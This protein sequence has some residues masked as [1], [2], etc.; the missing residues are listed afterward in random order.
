LLLASIAAGAQRFSFG[1]EGGA[2][3]TQPLAVGLPNPFATYVVNSN[4]YVVGA[5]AEIRITPRFGIGFDALM[6]HFSYDA[7][8]RYVPGISTFT[9]RTTANAWEFPLL[10][11]YRFRGAK[12]VSPVVT[13]GA[14]ADWL[15]GMRQAATVSTFIGGVSTIAASQPS[16][17]QQ[18]TVAG[19]VGGGGVDVRL[20]RI[21]FEPEVRYTFLAGRHFQAPGN[22]TM[23]DNRNRVEVLLGIVF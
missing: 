15:Q 18:R 5:C 14:A 10:G 11:R 1:V 12:P 17:L 22:G 21:H 3:V 8:G 2:P 23:W 13:A 19:L 4:P 7:S 6:R 9:S 20:R 16:E